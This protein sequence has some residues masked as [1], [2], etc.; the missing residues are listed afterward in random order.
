MKK[1]RLKY[2]TL[3]TE[4]TS[5]DVLSVDQ[6]DRFN[7]SL[8]ELGNI[9]EE[10]TLV[11]AL[12]V[13]FDLAGFT[14]FCNQNDPQ[15]VI[16]D[17]V[18]RFLNWLF[19]TIRSSLSSGRSDAQVKLWCRLPVFAKFLGDGLLFIWDTQRMDPTIE[20]GNVVIC[21]NDICSDYK[22][23]FVPKLADKFTNYPKLL[24]CGIARG[25]VVSIGGG[26]DYVGT[27]INVA[28][29]LQ[30]LG[31]LTFAFQKKGLDPSVIFDPGVQADFVTKRALVRGIGENELVVLK[32]SQFE[33]L[34]D[35]DRKHFK[36][37][38]EP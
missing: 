10:G 21:M 20:L 5:V 29:R 13:V 32:R 24:R 17:Y 15:L 26:R 31:S 23:E 33:A 34:S 18:N 14:A 30:K 9:A 36:N 35:D 8:L 25:Q 19:D 4:D 37:P 22:T 12:A 11:Q 7:S 6:F 28:S 16:P 38:D 3:K 2:R 1:L 27:C